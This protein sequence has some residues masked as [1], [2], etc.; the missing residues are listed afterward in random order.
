MPTTNERVAKLECAVDH[1]SG[2]IESLEKRL[3][4]LALLVVAAANGVDL[5]KLLVF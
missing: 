1:L 5:V 3:W 2:R 4:I